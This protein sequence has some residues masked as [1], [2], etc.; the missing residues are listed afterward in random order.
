MTKASATG[1]S[2][3]NSDSRPPIDQAGEHVAA[4][5]IGSERIARSTNRAQAADHAALIGVRQAELGRE[6]R[7]QDDQ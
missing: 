6:D 7:D 1:V 2:P 5:F 3:M 4:K